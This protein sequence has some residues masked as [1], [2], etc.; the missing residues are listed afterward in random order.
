[1]K[2]QHLTGASIGGALAAAFASSLCCLGP[3]LLGGL[4]L[5]GGALLARVD[6]YRPLLATL[7][8]ALLGAGFYF[9]YRSRRPVP[10]GDAAATT[11]DCQLPRANRLGRLVLWLATIAVAGL[12]AFPYLERLLVD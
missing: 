5:G 8:V 11:C 6:A 12:L 9:T 7:T 2:S 1:M 3:L 10:G 4:G